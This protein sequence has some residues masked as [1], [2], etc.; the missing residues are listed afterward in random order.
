VPEPWQTVKE[1]AR[2]ERVSPRTIFRWA[3][4]G[5][6]ER[7]RHG[8]AHRVRYRIRPPAEYRMVKAIR[9]GRYRTDAYG[10]LLIDD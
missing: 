6:V 9:E 2:L 8:T 10:E 7:G 5:I 3:K 1:L 4:L